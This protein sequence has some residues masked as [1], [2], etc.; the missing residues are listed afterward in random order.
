MIEYV[1]YTDES[2]LPDIQALVSRDLS[3]PYS[4]FTY[5]YFLHNW[6]QLCICAFANVQTDTEVKREMIG[7]IVCKAEQE[8]NGFNG[9]IA[10]LTVNQSYRKQG[11]G[12]KVNAFFCK[13]KF[14]D[15]VYKGTSSRIP[16]L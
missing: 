16:S 14:F 11:I 3:E 8:N 1:D 5:R 4:V 13:S 9:Y 6:P 15:K 7:T 2:M 12:L 10:M